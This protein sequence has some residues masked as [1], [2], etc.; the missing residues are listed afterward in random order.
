MGVITYQVPEGVQRMTI[1]V[2][3]EANVR[4][5][6]F[7][8]TEWRQITGD[9]GTAEM[10]VQRRGDSSPYAA[11][12]TMHDENTVSWVPT[13]ADTA[14]DGVGKL[15]LMWIA[16]G[17][18]VKT[19]IFDMKVDPALDY[20]LPDDSLDPWASWMPDVINAAAEIGSIEAQVDTR[21]DSQ[22]AAIA[23]IRAAVGSPL[24]ANTAAAMTDTEKVYVYTGDESGY[25]AG[26]WYYYDGTAWASGGVYN[27]AAVETD[28][29]LSVS[30]VPADAKAAGD[31][32]DSVKSHF[33]FQTSKSV[34][35]EQGYYAIADGSTIDSTSWCRSDYLNEDAILES[36][37]IKLFLLAY[38]L[39]GEYVGTWD[40][41]QK[42]FTTTYNSSGFIKKIVTREWLDS[43]PSYRFRVDYKGDS[44][45]LTP[46]DILNDL[47]VKKQI[48]IVVNELEDETIDVSVYPALLNKTFINA[49]GSL[50]TNTNGYETT[51]LIDVT[52]INKFKVNHMALSTTR[53]GCFYDSSEAAVGT[54]FSISENTYKSI[55][56]GAKYLRICSTNDNMNTGE[57]YLNKYTRITLIETRSN[58]NALDILNI[59]NKII[60]PVTVV[61]ATSLLSDCFINGNSGVVESAEGWHCTPYI[62]LPFDDQTEI[63][64]RSVAYGI[65]GCAFYDNEKQLVLGIKESN[66][67]QYGGVE[68]SLNIQ[69][70]TI[71]RSSIASAR[72]VRLSANTYQPNVTVDH[73]YA[74]GNTLVGAFEH[75]FR[76]EDDVQELNSLVST[77]IHDS[78]VLVVGDSISADAYGNY[79]KWV[80]VL[81]NQ[82]FL[83]NDTTNSSQHATGFVARYNNQANDFI[84]RLKGIQNPS[85]YDLVVVFGGIND[86]IQNIPLG[87]ATG[88]DYTVSFK[89]AVNEFFNYLINNFTQARL[90]VLTPLRNYQNWVNSVG[91][92]QEVYSE[93]IK[94][95]AKKYCLPVLNLTEDSGFCPYISSFS[96]MWT[97]IPEGYSVGDGTH[98]NEEYER[99]FL[100]PMIKHFL[101]GL[102]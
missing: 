67:S 52:G 2:Q 88:T 35:I 87:E 49:N 80:T 40:S 22:D 25:T 76:L 75:I 93:Y 55:P 51:E 5:F 9:L 59:K 13:A 6:L 74:K 79:A 41:A 33:I 28:T 26:N 21:L 43:Y 84:S 82:K 42:S 85:Q 17:Q 53:N 101:Q 15:Q 8:V 10:V 95:V 32:I 77:E 73:L 72:Y 83:P 100:A 78:K 69:T 16:S 12:I 58:E 66:C 38:T 70:L 60:D 97:L 30:G 90:C 50:D 45:S 1:G 48:E 44:N 7:D 19:K 61:K 11:A 39:D 92:K 94:T 89:P 91:V 102:M 24:V 36:N 27:S 68:G 96:D 56:S 20:D 18:T 34:Y 31:E 47:D 29:T 54:R 63:I 65:G 46:D 14:K 4:E 57:I 86:Y 37:S 98:P 99:R 64:V 62:E 71:S 23:A 81:K 3:G